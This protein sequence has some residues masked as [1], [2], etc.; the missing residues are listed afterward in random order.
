MWRWS[1]HVRKKDVDMVSTGEKEI[2][3]DGLYM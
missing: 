1:L 3:G 2:C